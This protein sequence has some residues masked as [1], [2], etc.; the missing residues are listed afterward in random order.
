M[1]SDPAVKYRLICIFFAT[2]LTF[3]SLLNLENTN[4]FNIRIGLTLGKSILQ[5]VRQLETS[6]LVP[7]NY[8]K[9]EL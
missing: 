2:H 1:R 4:I 6:D 5:G 8:S 9:R 3:F 7:H